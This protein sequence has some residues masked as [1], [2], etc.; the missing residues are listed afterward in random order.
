MKRIFVFSQTRPI[1]QMVELSLKA[2]EIELFTYTDIQEALVQLP[3]LLPHMALIDAEGMENQ[4]QQEI[5]KYLSMASK[6][7]W[8]GDGPFD[9]AQYVSIKKPLR[10]LE[11]KLALLGIIETP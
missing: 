3:Q 2:P 5:K 1:T 7:L 9:G 8:V 11:I 10:P 6:V 4:A